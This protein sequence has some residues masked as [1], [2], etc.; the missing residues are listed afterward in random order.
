MVKRRSEVVDVVAEDQS[1]RYG[2][3]ED[4]LKDETEEG[5]SSVRVGFLVDDHRVRTAIDPGL[6]FV[7]KRFQV[8]LGVLDFEKGARERQGHALTSS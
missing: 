2:R 6:H 5:D 8:T 7:L 1:D 4:V 3:I